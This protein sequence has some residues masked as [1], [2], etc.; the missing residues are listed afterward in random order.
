[1]SGI[2]DLPLKGN[3]IKNGW[4]LATIVQLQSGN[5]S[6]ISLI[7]PILASLTE[8]PAAKPSDRFPTRVFQPATRARRA[9]C[10]LP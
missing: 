2:Y 3:R 6:L 1:V 9:N 4:H 7:E 8:L 5:P 10:S